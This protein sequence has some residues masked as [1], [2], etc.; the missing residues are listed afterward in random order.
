MTT[1]LVTPPAP[2]WTGANANWWRIGYRHAH[3]GERV[4]LGGHLTSN[5]Y[6][7]G[8]QAGLA[9]QGRSAR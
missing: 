5:A 8:R 2:D 7:A 6:Q 4:S 1:T 9:A 3:T